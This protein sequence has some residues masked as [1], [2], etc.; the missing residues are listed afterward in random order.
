MFIYNFKNF[1]LIS[2]GSSDAERS[3]SF[4]TLL[5]RYRHNFKNDAIDALI[6]V[7]MNGPKQI[8][9]FRAMDYA[10]YWVNT[11]GR[12]RVDDTVK[13]VEKADSSPGDVLDHTY[14]DSSGL[15]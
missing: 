13:H 15:F 1:H 7:R 8:E 2:V 6:R 12:L 14:L 11:E 5:H 4:L 10:M 9:R 3:F